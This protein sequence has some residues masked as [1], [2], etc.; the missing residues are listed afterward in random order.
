VKAAATFARRLVAGNAHVTDS[1]SDK[2]HWAGV[3]PSQKQV[4]RCA[5]RD[6]VSLIIDV[7]DDD[8]EAMNVVILIFALGG[9]LRPLSHS[10]CVSYSR[11]KGM[12]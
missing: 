9:H 11:P 8:I 5:R 2:R 12:L 6:R 4:S 10:V 7:F 3:K 1:V